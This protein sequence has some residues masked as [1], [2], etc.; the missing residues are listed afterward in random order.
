MVG[1]EIAPDTK[2]WGGPTGQ[3]LA[4]PVEQ[5]IL[6]AQLP[7]NA[8]GLQLPIPSPGRQQFRPS[9]A[10]SMPLFVSRSGTTQPLF[11]LNPA[12]N[13]KHHHCE[14]KKDRLQHQCPIATAVVICLPV[15]IAQAGLNRPERERVSQ[16]RSSHPRWRLAESRTGGSALFSETTSGFVARV[17][18]RPEAVLYTH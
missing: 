18:F 5:E 12:R 2:S 7:A 16:S 1:F 9:G 15:R 10:A 11:Q 17:L 6:P 13:Q 14:A 3:L 8:I 4:A